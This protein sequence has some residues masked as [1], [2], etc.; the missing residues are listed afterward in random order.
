MHEAET[1]GSV[2]HTISAGQNLRERRRPRGIVIAPEPSHPQRNHDR[3]APSDQARIRNVSI[4]MAAT[5]GHRARSVSRPVAA[6]TLRFGQQQGSSKSTW[7][8]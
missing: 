1:S 8:T 5:T 7:K 6:L 4:R 3:P 2:H